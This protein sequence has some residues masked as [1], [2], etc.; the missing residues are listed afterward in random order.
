[1]WAYVVA[2]WLGRPSTAEHLHSRFDMVSAQSFNEGSLSADPED[3]ENK[4][5]FNKEL[6]RK[7]KEYL[8]LGAIAGVFTGVADGM[9]KEILGTCLVFGGSSSGAIVI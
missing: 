4:S 6:T 2:E 8:V 9:Q 5:F 7:M 3:P 1:V